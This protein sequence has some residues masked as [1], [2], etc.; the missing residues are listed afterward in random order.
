MKPK[1]D[2]LAWGVFAGVAFAGWILSFGIKGQGLESGEW[3][4][5]QD[6]D[7]DDEYEDE[8]DVEDSAGVGS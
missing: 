7:D 2:A 1:G 5:S 6:D 4:G 3:E 8:E